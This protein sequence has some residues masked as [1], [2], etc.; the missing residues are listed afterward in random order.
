LGSEKSRG[1]TIKVKE[2]LKVIERTLSSRG[3][4]VIKE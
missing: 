1:W 3:F 4:A 2:I